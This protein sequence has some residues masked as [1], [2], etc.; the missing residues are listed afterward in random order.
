MSEEQ[1][2]N[3]DSSVEKPEKKNKKKKLLMLLLVIL[4]IALV[5]A[6]AI[7]IFVYFTKDK[8]PQQKEETP[9]LAP[10][11]APEDE[12][13]GESMGDEGEEKLDQ[14]KGGGAVSLTYTKDVV[15]D[16]SEN[17]VSLLFGN[18]SRSNQGMVLQV[19]I[20]DKVIVQSGTLK[21]GIQVKELEL[22]GNA[23]LQPGIYEGKFNVLYYDM[24]SGNK[25][26]VNTEIPI[27]I[28]V[29]K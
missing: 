19:I 21:P 29:Q 3:T 26:V 24:D 17:K 13:N 7:G 28:K 4:G 1:I 20:Q 14:P 6:L 11:R 2:T 5:A 16:L 25:A 18:P 27:D 15:I 23:K 22:T 10:D 12:E 9:I 8:A